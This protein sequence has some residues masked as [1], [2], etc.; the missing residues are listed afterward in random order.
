MRNYK[1][2]YKDYSGQKEQ[3]KERASRNKSR[4]T[5]IDKYG[6]QALKNKDID[7]KDHNPLNNK[8]S[9]L[10]IRSIKSNRSDNN[11]KFL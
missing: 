8:I 7:H 6:H 10:R 1:K 2:E 4:K 9:N 3:I 5:M 11:H